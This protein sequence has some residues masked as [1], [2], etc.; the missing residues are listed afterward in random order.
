MS[1]RGED[2]AFTSGDIMIQWCS[3]MCSV[4]EIWEKVRGVKVTE[5]IGTG[6]LDVIGSH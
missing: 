4:R 2:P 1:T 5:Q 6:R 3:G